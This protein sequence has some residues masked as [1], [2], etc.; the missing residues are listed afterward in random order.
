MLHASSLKQ[1]RNAVLNFVESRGLRT[2]GSTVITDH[3]PTLTEF[4]YIT[5]AAD[6][7]IGDYEDLDLARIDPVSQ[8]AKSHSIPLIW[9][10]STYIDAMLPELW[11]RQS[12][13]GYCSGISVA[14][15]LP[16]GMHFMFGLDSDKPAC[17]ERRDERQLAEEVYLFAAHAQAAAFE[18]CAP[19]VTS[20]ENAWGLTKFELEPLR[21][22]MDGLTNW[23]IGN[24]LGV[25]EREVARRLHRS[26]VKLGC[27]TRYETV[28]RAIKLGLI[29]CP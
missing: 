26:C 29:Q 18:L 4:Q 19:C 17:C 23:E 15:H 27:A 24:K 22:A 25:S 1:Y 14:F 7:Y 10:R 11:D 5:N 9:N 28:L 3:S 2:F 12:P 16:R 20:Q 6:D 13:F 8:H 21:W